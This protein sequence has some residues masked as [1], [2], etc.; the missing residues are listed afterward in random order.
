MHSRERPSRD[1]IRS[2]AREIP[3]PSVSRYRRAQRHRSRPFVI[4]QT[5][6]TRGA[7]EPVG[8]ALLEERDGTRREDNRAAPRAAVHAPPHEPEP[9][10]AFDRL[11]AHPPA[12]REGVDR[13]EAR[14][15]EIGSA[16][17]GV[18]AEPLGEG[19]Q[20]AQQR[21]AAQELGLVELGAV[22]RDA[23]DDEVLGVHPLGIEDRGERLDAVQVFQERRARGEAEL[24]A[25]AGDRSRPRPAQRGHGSPAP[26][27]R[28]GSIHL[29]SRAG[30]RSCVA[31]MSRNRATPSRARASGSKRRSC[32]M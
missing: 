32:P 13:L 19:R 18:L 22:A 15:V 17:P 27:V 20:I 16:A 8:V 2:A 4:R 21:R 29:G 9:T 28:G 5:R 23:E 11:A 30:S 7:P 25:Q 3:H 26:A 6:E 10:V 14:V 31:A 12:G 24:L 1:A